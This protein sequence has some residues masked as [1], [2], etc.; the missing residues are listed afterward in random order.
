MIQAKAEADSSDSIFSSNPQAWDDS[1]IMEIFADSIRNHEVLSKKGEGSNQNTNKKHKRNPKIARFT[2]LSKEQVLN[3][4]MPGDWSTVEARK[5]STDNGIEEG[6]VLEASSQAPHQQGVGSQQEP[7]KSISTHTP[8]NSGT[9]A[10]HI[11]GFV[12]QSELDQALQDMVQTSYAA[13]FAAGRYHALKDLS[14]QQRNHNAQ[15]NT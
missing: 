4:A 7:D 6:E 3:Q 1:I 11:G 12:C 2:N 9:T 10:F 13:G 5:S 15:T 8:E 14:S